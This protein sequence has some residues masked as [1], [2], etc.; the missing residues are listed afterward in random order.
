MPR[1]SKIMAATA[2]VAAATGIAMA[3]GKKLMNA[4]GNGGSQRANGSALPAVF[5]VR[6][7]DD[8][9]WRVDSDDGGIGGERHSTKGR[10]VR[11][12]RKLAHGSKPSRLV[13]HRGDGSVQREHT[14]R[15]KA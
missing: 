11:A 3:A 4:R 2:G 8:G 14:Y 12:A 10:A 5:H 1:N 7:G 9:S 13:I 6:S 15:K